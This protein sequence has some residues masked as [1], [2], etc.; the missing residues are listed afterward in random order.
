MHR[1]NLYLARLK[2]AHKLILS[3]AVF[4][5]P[6]AVLLYFSVASFSQGIRTTEHEIV[7]SHALERLPVLLADLRRLQLWSYLANEGARVTDS[8]LEDASKRVDSTIKALD[9]FSDPTV[10]ELVE[11]MAGLWKQF[12]DPNRAMTVRERAMT[13]RL[14]IETSNQLVPVTLDQYRLVT[15]PEMDTYYLVELTGL[16]LARAQTAT[17]QARLVALRSGVEGRIDQRD[18]AVLQTQGELLS[19]T[20]V[21]RMRRALAIALQED[22]T[23]HGL[24][25]TLQKVLPPLCERYLSSLTELS[26][27]L[28]RFSDMTDSNLTTD[29]IVRTAAQTESYGT[30]FAGAAIPELRTLLEKRISDSRRSRALALLLSLLSVALAA[31]VMALVVRNITSPLAKVVDLTTRIAAGRVK[32]AMDRF[33]DDDFRELFAIEKASKEVRDETFGLIQSVYTMTGNLNTLLA[34]VTAACGQ[35]AGSANVTSSTVSE[36]EAA[37]AEQAAS[38]NQVSSTSK[39]I[40]VTARDLAKTMQSVT[41]MAT[42]AAETAHGGVGSLQGIHAAIDMLVE[43]SQSMM[44]SFEAIQEK[45]GNIDKVITS[46]TKI[47]NRTN[48]LSLN[49]AIEA[50]KAGDKA[51]GFSVVALEVRRLADQ[52]AVAALDI[53]RQIRDMQHAVGDGMASIASYTRRTEASSAAV[54]ELS[55]GLGKVIE[56]TTRLGP[57]FESVNMGMQMQSQGAGQIAE[58]MLHLRDA[59]SQTRVALAEFR[60]VAEDLHRAVGE[61]QAEVG[62]FSTAS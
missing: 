37:V 31:G 39:Q 29:K 51:G 42:E 35:V 13:Y 54:A 59:A 48:L 23:F 2:I 25:P 4:A 44:R 17:A 9:R 27:Q 49:A 45:A 61:L 36:L 14:L 8:G 15:D 55:E 20:L 7:G 56:G 41:G 16:L 24:S 26:D 60:K 53:E 28:S 5:L 43:T 22:A 30:A 10:K 19:G 52:T 3:S 38:T 57:E 32:E 11:K 33:H 21:P 34:K 18:L 12:R 47:A 50:E 46:I 6:I 40:H 58:S 62:R 1:I